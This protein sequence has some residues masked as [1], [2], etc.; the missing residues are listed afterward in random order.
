MPFA[1]VETANRRLEAAVS[2]EEQVETA[3]DSALARLDA[4]VCEVAQRKLG[5]TQQLLDQA[6]DELKKINETQTAASNAGV[7]S[8]TFDGTQPPRRRRQQH[9]SGNFLDGCETCPL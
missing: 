6:N 9:G 5:E 4:A 2:A 8:Y 7:Q 1:A 3:I